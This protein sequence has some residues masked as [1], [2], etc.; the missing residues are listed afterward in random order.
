MSDI[1]IIKDDEFK[2]SV[3]KY[4]LPCGWCELKQKECG[5]YFAMMYPRNYEPYMPNTT[6]VYAAPSGAPTITCNAERSEE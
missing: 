2:I 3:C 6:S 1:G 4:Y 5:K